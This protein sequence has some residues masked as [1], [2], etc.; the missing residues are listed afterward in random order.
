MATLDVINLELSDAGQRS[1]ELELDRDL[2]VAIREYAPD[3]KALLDHM[4][5]APGFEEFKTFSHW[6][7]HC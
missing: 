2:R 7:I 1:R 6:S 5:T 3:A 4:S